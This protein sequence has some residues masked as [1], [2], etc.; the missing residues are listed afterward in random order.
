MGSEAAGAA[1][2][3]ST[4]F[5]CPE[6]IRTPPLWMGGGCGRVV[7]DDDHVVD[8]RVPGGD[9]HPPFG[10]GCGRV[11]DDVDRAPSEGAQQRARAR[12]DSGP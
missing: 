12:S 9:T 7:V 6:A 5:V 4:V 10:G 2:A 1:A 3:V 11:V 8:V